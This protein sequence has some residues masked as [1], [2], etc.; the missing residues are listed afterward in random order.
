MMHRYTATIWLPGLGA[1]R[2]EVQA[3]DVFK[4]TTMLKS[5]YASA[6]ITNVRRV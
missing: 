3:D 4:A 2:V 5:L 6:K 1:Q